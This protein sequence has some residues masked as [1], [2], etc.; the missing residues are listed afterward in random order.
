[1]KSQQSI[2]GQGGAYYVT[3][4]D[5]RTFWVDRVEVE[6]DANDRLVP[7]APYWTVM[8]QHGDHVGGR[9]PAKAAAMAY[10]SRLEAA[11]VR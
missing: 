3:L 7:V 9:F 1:M 5:G 8:N 2:P 4:A 10:L 11:D 6:T